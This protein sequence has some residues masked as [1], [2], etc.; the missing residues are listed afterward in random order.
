VAESRHSSDSDFIFGTLFN[1]KPLKG[2][3]NV[4]VPFVN[5]TYEAATAL[6]LLGHNA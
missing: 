4:G 2:E 1:R 6:S 3:I 5:P